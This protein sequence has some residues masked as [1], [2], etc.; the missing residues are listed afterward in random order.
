MNNPLYSFYGEFFSG[1]TLINIQDSFAKSYEAA[2]K[3]YADQPFLK[4]YTKDRKTREKTFAEL[5]GDVEQ[6]RLFLLH[7]YADYEVVITVDGNTYE[8]IVF[9]LA[10]ILGGFTLSPM[11]PNEGAERILGKQRQIGQKSIVFAGMTAQDLISSGTQKLEIPQGLFSSRASKVRP[12]DIPIIL[13]FTSGTTGYSKV[14]QQS[15]LG[16]LA[17][18]DALIE[19]HGLDVRK[20]IA[21]PLPIF[22]VNA[23]E[24]ALFCSLFSGQRL[25]LFDGF[26][27]ISILNSLSADQ[28][29]ILSL[30]PHALKSLLDLKEKVLLQATHLDYCVTA[31]SSLSP[32]LAKR[33][34]EEFPFKIIQGY[35]LSEAINF[36][37][38][39]R[40]MDSKRVID[41]WLTYF[42]RPSI[43]TPVR[44]NEVRILS[45]D[46]VVQDEGVEG[47]ICIR[48]PGIMFGYKG[49]D[50][51]A[52]FSGDYLHT[53]DRGFFRICKETGL[54]Y[55]FISGR[56]KDVI[57]RF[58]LTVS[59]VEIDDILTSWLPPKEIAAI[60]VPFDNEIAGEE[61]GVAI[62]GDVTENDIN[63]LKEYLQAELPS[64][65]R[66]RVIVNTKMKLRTDSGK[67]QRWMVAPLFSDFR[68][69]VFGEKV[70]SKKTD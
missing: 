21:T 44:G 2:A 51:S 59:L 6:V 25:V 43:G 27:F 66:P 5:H 26:D 39:N 45:E 62:S 42:T 8:N 28:V 35:G 61:V 33:L 16:L 23:L 41:Y 14:V 24:F 18:I 48:G 20:V 32:E 31:A 17:N 10:A 57:K 29:Q 67:P 40:P 3:K 30:V 4:I 64:L 36:S 7:Q 1:G 65:M 69:I 70:H 54:P 63:S 13:I 58:G 22:H 50:N 46:G 68:K 15:E 34:A 38:L 49:Q 11:N 60:A 55:F 52:V 53:G 56:M 19:L 37:L 9:M 12:K 47:E